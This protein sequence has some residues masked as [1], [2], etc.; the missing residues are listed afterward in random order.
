MAKHV[1]LLGLLKAKLA[2]SKL[3]WSKKVY[4]TFISLVKHGK[5]DRDLTMQMFIKF[6]DINNS[7]RPWNVAKLWAERIMEVPRFQFLE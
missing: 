4:K 1:E 2:G 6:S 7:S 5:T 3:D